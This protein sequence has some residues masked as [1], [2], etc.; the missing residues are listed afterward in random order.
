M[1]D[2]PFDLARFIRA[3]DQQY[4]DALRELRA[5]RKQSHWIWF[6]FPQL[7]ALG[8]SGTARLYGL[9]NVEEAKAYWAHPVLGRRLLDGV[10]AMLSI[11]GK[12]A[13]AILGDIDALKFRSCLTLFLQAAPGQPELS[14]A[15]DRLYNG[16]PDPL[17][18]ALLGRDGEA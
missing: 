15:L 3:Q 5:G 1:N 14:A 10:A 7:R 17:T 8:R 13:A 6:V 16:E 2:D 12:S 4:Q 18:L 11:P 9:A